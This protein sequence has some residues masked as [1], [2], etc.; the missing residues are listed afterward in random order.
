MG[1]R[2]IPI[3][4]KFFVSPQISEK[5]IAEAK[6]RGV[7]LIINNR[8]DGEAPFQPKTAELK[9]AA[10]AAGI[11]YVDIP[12]SRAGI[13]PDHLDAFDKAVLDNDGATLAF[14]RTGTRSTMLRALACARA[15]A[16]ADEI[17]NEAANAGYDLGPYK[18]M[19]ETL[20]ARKG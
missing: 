3:A 19:L 6:A 17:L 4:E 2:F 12:V 8:P 13:S 18:R 14:C 1:A 10:E 15:G 11:S 20:A 7:T 16:A 5:D 9:A